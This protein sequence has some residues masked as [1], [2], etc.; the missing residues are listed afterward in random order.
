MKVVSFL[1]V[2][3]VVVEPLMV[4]ESVITSLPGGD[5]P[6]L[7]PPQESFDTFLSTCVMTLCGVQLPFVAAN[8]GAAGAAATTALLVARAAG[9]AAVSSSR[10]ILRPII[11]FFLSPGFPV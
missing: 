4:N 10:D 1:L 8:A 6:V 3:T 11:S 2:L 5:H 9:S 7:R